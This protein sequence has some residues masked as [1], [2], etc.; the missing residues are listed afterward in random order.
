[1]KYQESHR[2]LRPRHALAAIAVLGAWLAPS[3]HA[4]WDPETVDSAG[5]VG[6]YTSMAIDADGK[7]HVAY[8]A[9]NAVTGK[10]VLKHAWIDNAGA[11]NAE[12][13]PSPG[14]AIIVA[15]SAPSVGAYSSI[16]IDSAGRIHIAYQDQTNLALLH[17]QKNPAG[18]A[19]AGVWQVETLDRVASQVA[20]TS[21]TTSLSGGLDSLHVSYYDL[22]ADNLMYATC[23][24]H[25]EQ[26]DPHTGLRHGWA[27]QDQ[28]VASSGD[29]GKYNSIA[30]GSNGKPQISYYDETNDRLM[31]A[32]KVFGGF[33]GG[34]E[35]WVWASQIV[36]APAGTDVGMYSSLAFA[37]NGTAHISYYDQTNTN[38]KHAW[39]PAGGGWSKETVDAG[40]WVIGGGDVRVGQYTSIACTSSRVYIS[41]H[42]DDADSLKYA[43]LWTGP[44]VAGS[45]VPTWS[46]ETVDNPAASVGTYTS[47]KRSSS[48]VVWISYYDTTNGD[49]KVA[50]K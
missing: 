7:P 29:V 6:K 19:L 44:V 38:L 23:S 36:D 43:T 42:N 35:N 1:M 33:I 12:A 20:Y 17:A 39:K 4:Q 26:V 22:A 30:M 14:P 25:E 47:I 24:V 46:K 49:L 18:Q 3:S 5:S 13:V 28:I 16:C 31:C 2:A 45:G 41:Y 9:L 21:I 8:R 10:Y 27:L 37:P 11:W 48:G 40:G 50:S 15:G 32:L 34:V